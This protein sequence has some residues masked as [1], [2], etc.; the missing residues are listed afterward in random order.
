M[1]ADIGRLRE[2][3]M[4]VGLGRAD[5]HDN[6]LVQFRK[7]LDQANRAGI[8]QP[9]AMSLAT[10]SKRGEVRAC[11]PSC[12]SSTMKA[13]FVFFTNYESPKSRDIEANSSV[14]A[15][16]PWIDLERQVVVRRGV[17]ERVPV[18]LSR[19]YF[20]SRPRG[21]RLGAWASRQSSPIPSRA[22]LEEKVAQMEEEF[23]DGPVPLPDSWGGYRIVPHRI[24]FWQG[25]PNRLHDR[26]LYEKM[27]DSARWK[28]QRLSP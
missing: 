20:L 22:V 3:Y 16:F 2:A 11:A 23:R 14:A 18:S 15:L 24:E 6:P 12:S 27:E 10:A 17:A 13:G 28:I 25:R 19:K 7:W 26:F 21:S 5:L 1:R 8:V 9:N 4:R